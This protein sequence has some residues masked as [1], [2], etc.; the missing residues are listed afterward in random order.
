MVS[1]HSFS[2]ILFHFEAD[3]VFV[4]CATLLTARKRDSAVK[5]ALG[6]QVDLDSDPGSAKYQ[7]FDG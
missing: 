3:S 4:L 6:G 7:L 1:S 5:E 2:N